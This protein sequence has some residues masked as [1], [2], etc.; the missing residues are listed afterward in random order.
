VA[1][2][3]DLITA[4]LPGPMA[5]AFGDPVTFTAAGGSPQAV[6]GLLDDPAPPESGYPGNVAIVEILKADL[7]G[8]PLQGDAVTTGAHSYIVFDVK[9]DD[10]GPGGL[11]WKLALH[12]TA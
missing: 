8:T 12:K 1:L 11:Y 3:D 4:A 9:S 10:V 2:I 5:A 6:T 7:V